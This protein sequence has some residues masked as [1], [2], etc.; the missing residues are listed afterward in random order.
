MKRQKKQRQKMHKKRQSKIVSLPSAAHCKYLKGEK[1]KKIITI[2]WQVSIL[3]V[4]VL[5][6]ELLTRF[7]SPSVRFPDRYPFI[8][9]FLFSS[10]SRIFLTLIDLSKDRLLIHI[11]TTL[12]ACIIGFSLSTLLGTAIATLLWWS[13]RTRAVLQP[14]LVVLNA[15]P[16]V[17][18]GPMIII[19]VGVGM[20]AIVVM[21]VLICII[22]TVISVLNGFLTIDGGKILLLKSMGARDWQIFIK[23]ILPGSAGHLLS[24]LKVNIGLAWVGTIMG[25]YL[26]SRAGLGYLILYGGTV[27]KMDLVMTSI[28]ILCVLAGAMYLGV[29]GLERVIKK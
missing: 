12:L 28:V 1:N 27:F 4:F 16:K 22:V 6:W 3:L 7:P 13:K 10:P 8:D 26:V 18:L 19:W 14:Y 20:Q 21:T 17:A 2:V 15:L 9:A 11:G 5:L 24:A 23:L 25:E 29:S